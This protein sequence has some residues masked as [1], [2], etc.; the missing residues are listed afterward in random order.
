[1]LDHWRARIG[2]IH[3]RVNSDI[4]VYDFCSRPKTWCWS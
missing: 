3:P 4:E 1:M 2:W